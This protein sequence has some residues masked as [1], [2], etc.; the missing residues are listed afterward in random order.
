MRALFWRRKNARLDSRLSNLIETSKRARQTGRRKKLRVQID[1]SYVDQSSFDDTA[2]AFSDPYEVAHNGTEN[3]DRLTVRQHDSGASANQEPA[4]EHDSDEYDGHFSDGLD[5]DDEI[6]REAIEQLEQAEARE[7]DA[8]ARE[9][10]A[11]EDASAQR[12]LIAQLEAEIGRE[13]ANRVLAEQS[14]TTQSLDQVRTAEGEIA[15]LRT[16]AE[17]GKAERAALRKA[18]ETDRGLIAALEADL[19]VE[20]AARAELEARLANAQASSGETDQLIEDLAAL[21]VTAAEAQQSLAEAA[22]Q[23]TAAIARADH[24]EAEQNKLMARIDAAEKSKVNA[25][26]ACTEA[27]VRAHAAEQALQ[28]AQAELADLKAANDQSQATEQQTTA[29]AIARA[30][31]AEAALAEQRTIAECQVAEIA[32]LK[33]ARAEQAAAAKTVADEMEQLRT[34]A[35]QFERAERRRLEAQSREEAAR[36]EA[37]P[38]REKLRLLD[39]ELASLRAAFADVKAQRE[40]AAKRATEARKE[41]EQLR[42]VASTAAAQ[43]VPP[44]VEPEPDRET[45]VAEIAPHAASKVAEHEVPEPP[46]LDE[47]SAEMDR[48]STKISAPATP[49]ASRRPQRIVPRQDPEGDKPSSKPTDRSDDQP[50]DK[51]A[52]PAPAS[53]PAAH[54]PTAVDGG[55]SLIQDRLALAV[56]TKQRTKENRRAKRV[57]SRKLA[58]LW[59][60]QMSAALSCTMM[61]RSSTGAKLEVLEDRYNNRMND[62][63]VGDRFTLTLNYAQ[64]TTSIPC[65]VMWVAGR[66]CGVRFCGQILTQVTKQTKKA[67]PK[68]APEK[69][70]TGS[71][72]KS[73]FGAGSR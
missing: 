65:E 5:Q 27:K 55:S 42:Q 39:A 21:R 64:E 70:T 44:Q 66:K 45:D 2:A 20:R 34:A 46:P 68:P 3:T 41:L 28:T 18:A 9:K 25:E 23:K 29:D 50:S 22:A 52:S 43:A 36:K 57:A 33:Q 12:Q 38:L 71:A 62:L 56:S 48:A 19:S 6:L 49:P 7:A 4:I 15:A 51:T 73:L 32:H 30:E 14:A 31:K 40:G 47:T 72:I 1:T 59:N 53:A 69:P 17:A 67:S 8:L 61:D 13:R 63:S 11:L 10:A 16:A 35:A 26:Q 60:E 54:T 58:S 24:A 37:E